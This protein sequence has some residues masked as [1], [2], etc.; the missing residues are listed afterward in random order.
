M[1]E[2]VSGED[3]RTVHHLARWD[4]AGKRLAVLAVWTC[5]AYLEDSRRASER[6]DSQ[7]VAGQY[8]RGLGLAARSAGCCHEGRGGRFLPRKGLVGCQFGKTSHCATVVGDAGF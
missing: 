2:E 4:R 1:K 8:N 3:K 7:C 6:T 5:A